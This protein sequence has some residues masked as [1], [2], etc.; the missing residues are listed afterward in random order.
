ME[1]GN[2]ILELRKRNNFSQEQLAEKM[3]AARQTISKWELGETTSDLA[4]SKILSQIFNV[5]LD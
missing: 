5:S 3:G 2:K 1:I 4:Q